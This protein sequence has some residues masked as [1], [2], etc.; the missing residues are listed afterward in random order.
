MG[1]EDLAMIC[2]EPDF[3][4][5][6]PSDATSA[7]KA[8]RLVGESEGPSYVRL[9]RMN[10][11]VLY[12]PEEPFAIGKCKVLRRS[13]QDRALVVA[14]GSP[15]PKLSR[16]PTSYVTVASRC[17]SSICSASSRSIG[18]SWWPRPARL[19]EWSSP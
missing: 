16:L 14:A 8:A 15:F 2:A 17:A 3:T 11:P 10:S 7:W 13:D 9:G 18:T 19:L 6:Y 4:V 1:L 5:L 12:G